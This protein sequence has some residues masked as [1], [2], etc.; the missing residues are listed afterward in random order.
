MIV[1]KM[2]SSDDISGYNSPEANALKDLIDELEKNFQEPK[3]ECL[4]E[5]YYYITKGGG[6]R[7]GVWIRINKSDR[8]IFVLANPNDSKKTDIHSAVDLKC[9]KYPQPT[10]GK[11]YLPEDFTT[12]AYYEGNSVES[13]DY[14][15]L[16]QEIINRLDCVC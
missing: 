11:H 14:N 2:S 3:G 10:P 6:F 4:L 9:P 8:W 5:F 15:Q 7:N 16:M 12:P 13:I 1:K